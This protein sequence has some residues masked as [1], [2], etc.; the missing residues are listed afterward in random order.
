VKTLSEEASG[1]IYFS[2]LNGQEIL[3]VNDEAL[4]LLKAIQV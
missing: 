1:L 4:A 3:A 2:Q